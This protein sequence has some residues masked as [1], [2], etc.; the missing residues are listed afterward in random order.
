MTNTYQSQNPYQPV[1]GQTYNDLRIEALEQSFK[2]DMHYMKGILEA[3]NDS[4][5]RQFEQLLQLTNE[6]QIEKNQAKDDLQ[7]LK[8]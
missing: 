3:Q 8:R 1:L 2:E 4:F 7:E 6:K 5:K